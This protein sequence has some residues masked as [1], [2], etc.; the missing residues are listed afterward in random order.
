MHCSTSIHAALMQMSD[1]GSS[2]SLCIPL[3][4]SLVLSK[5][6]AQVSVT[7]LAFLSLWLTVKNHKASKLWEMHRSDQYKLLIL[8]I[9]YSW[10]TKTTFKK[11][12]TWLWINSV[13]EAN[14]SL[15]ILESEKNKRTFVVQTTGRSVHKCIWDVTVQ[16]SSDLRYS[17]VQKFEVCKIFCLFFKEVSYAHRVSIY[18]IKPLLRYVI[19]I[20]NNDPFLFLIHF[21][22]SF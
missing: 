22:K 21:K 17:A 5:L 13:L 15:W 18:L 12:I 4:Y 1:K 20:H 11:L 8:F 10:I 7:N 9:G 16:L 6:F 2:Y 19:S 14:H 3:T